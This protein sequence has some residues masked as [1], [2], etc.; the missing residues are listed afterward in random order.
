[1]F[2]SLRQMVT[3]IG[4]VTTFTEARGPNVMAA[5]WTMLVSKNPPL[6]MVVIRKSEATNEMIMESREYGVSIAAEDQA[7]VVSL[8]GSFSGYE[9]DKFS[10][11]VIKIRAAKKIRAPMIAGAVMYAECKLKQS[12]DL[13]EYTA[14]VGEAVEASHDPLKRPLAY[15]AGRLWKLHESERPDLLYVAGTHDRTKNSVKAEGR[16]RPATSGGVE[17]ILRGGNQSRNFPAQPDQ[18][19]YYDHEWNVDGKGGTYTIDAESAGV[20]AR[21]TVIQKGE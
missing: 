21:A 9:T 8:A 1:M 10:S 3:G 2:G 6:L 11:E 20:R 14:F 4:L 18:S 13:G 19:G 15:H 12:L 5:E 16:V 17:L 7:D